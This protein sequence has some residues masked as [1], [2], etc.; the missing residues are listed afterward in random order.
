MTCS[1]HNTK[2]N[3]MINSDNNAA[4]NDAEENDSDE[5]RS[6]QD[7]HSDGIDP[8]PPTEEDELASEIDNLSQADKAS[9]SSFTLNVDQG[10]APKKED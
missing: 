10:I 5:Q 8:V 4:L 7:V 3:K 1:I 6:Q 2:I 9:E